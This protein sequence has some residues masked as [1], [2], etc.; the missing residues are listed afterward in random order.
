MQEAYLL[1][2]ENANKST[3]HG[4]IQHDKKATFTK[5]LVGNM[6]LYRIQVN[7]EDQEN[8]VHCGIKLFI[9]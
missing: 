6:Y 1:A 2:T 8:C 7:V 5:L 3:V 9:V 4:R